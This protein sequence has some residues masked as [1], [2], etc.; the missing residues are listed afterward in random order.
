MLTC[1]VAPLLSLYT[2]VEG[3]VISQVARKVEGLKS[4][5]LSEI[6]ASF[7]KRGSIHFSS[8]GN[9]EELKSSPECFNT[10]D[11]GETG[12]KET[13]FIA[14]AAAEL[15][16][17][18][19][20]NAALAAWFSLQEIHMRLGADETGLYSYV[21]TACGILGGVFA[22]PEL[23]L[24]G[25]LFDERVVL[26]PA[27]F[28]CSESWSKW[29]IQHTSC[30]TLVICVLAKGCRAS[31]GAADAQVDVSVSHFMAVKAAGPA[32]GWAGRLLQVCA[33]CQQQGEGW[34]RIAFWVRLVPRSQPK[35]HTACISALCGRALGSVQRGDLEE[36]NEMNEFLFSPLSFCSWEERKSQEE[37]IQDAV[38]HR[39]CELVV[40]HKYVPA[41]GDVEKFLRE[42]QA[43]GV[44]LYGELMVN[45][46]AKQQELAYKC[47]AA[48][49]EQMDVSSA[50]VVAEMLF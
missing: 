18:S 49:R 23:P 26:V 19:S 40:K 25:L 42:D 9:K 48:A 31:T 34:L 30:T 11:F 8:G 20:M 37:R 28:T 10:G 1:P 41:Y 36:M 4:S 32:R 14:D 45:E 16:L 12:G 47:F 39:W 44:Y 21:T 29:D 7:N 15:G 24:L 22:E 50:K 46:D 5:D 6:T 43:M 27:A 3:L 33:F 13:G 38:R 17:S 35:G 2:P